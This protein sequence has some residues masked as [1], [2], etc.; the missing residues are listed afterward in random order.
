M[1][2]MMG[3]LRH[4]AETLLS[5]STRPGHAQG[6]YLVGLWTV[7]CL[8]LTLATWVCFLVDLKSSTVAFVYLIIIV[9]L[10]L[11]DSFASSVV[12]SLFALACL[13]YIFV[14]PRFT[15]QVEYSEDILQL[16]A[17]VATSF[18]ITGLV[19][20]MRTLAQAHH[21]QARLLDLTHDSVFVRDANDVIVYWNRGAQELYG[22]TREEI[23]GRITHDLLQTEFPI[24]LDEINRQLLD[25]GRWEGELRHTRRDGTKI[26][27]ASRWSLQRDANG[28]VTGTLESNNDITARKR[29]EAALKRSQDT[30]LA[31]AQKLST[32]G[33][34]GW[35]ALTGEL[36]WSEESFRIYG[37]DSALKPS[38]DAIFERA[39]PDDLALVRR[40]FER[41]AKEKGECD[42]E[43]RLL[44]PDGSVRHLRVVARVVADEPEV[45]QFVGAVMDVTAARQAEETLHQAQTELAYVTRVTTLG[46]LAASIAH[47]INQPLSA[48]V[49]SGDASLR[50]LNRDPPQLDEVRD[51]VKRMISDG[52]RAS[53]IVQRIRALTKK[54]ETQST[55]VD[56]NNL[57]GES[58]ALVRREVANHQVA[59]RTELVPEAPA[60][61]GDGVLLQQVL[62]NLIVNGVQA[63]GEINGQPRELVIRS[64]HEAGEI[65]V[66][67]QDSGTGIAPETAG[68]LFDA[69]YTTKPNG[70]GMG[71]SICRTII[72]AHGGRVWASNNAGPGA[73]F[74]FSLPPIR[75]D[76]A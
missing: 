72:E 38:I 71:L 46:E 50:F 69:F 11:L 59:L 1:G 63:M 19:R 60:V 25:T 37:F 34:F 55:R 26:F 5:R 52:K 23:V 62:I 22:W 2:Q 56:L 15:F 12:F 54:T 4:H 30:Y 51:A 57:V 33:S 65:V 45:L 27:V 24:P 70:M 31:E 66:S 76:A 21:E 42:F 20:R 32:T 40:V 36:H 3:W 68:R 44:M 7:G 48:I 41:A 47:E 16:I 13:D 67:V 75:E 43:H 28:R 18:I 58:V 8:S 61:L 49:T 6:R 29:T 53:T 64:S 35:N 39:H 9:L 73:T 17:F 14:E 74:H 10:S